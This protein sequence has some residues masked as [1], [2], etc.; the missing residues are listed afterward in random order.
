MH[1]DLEIAAALREELL[2]IRRHLGRRLDRHDAQH[3][4]LV[5]YLAAEEIVEWHIE[6]ARTE[7][8]QRAVDAGLGLAGAGERAIERHE[9]GFDRERVLA[10]HMRLEALQLRRQRL[11]GRA[12]VRRGIGIA[13]AHVPTVGGEPHDIAARGR[14]RA[15]REGPVLVLERHDARLELDRFDDHQ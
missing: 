12:H 9:N 15:E 14:G 1:L 5:A 10:K 6:R 3:W 11:E 8:V 2:G 4:N 13:V 7:I